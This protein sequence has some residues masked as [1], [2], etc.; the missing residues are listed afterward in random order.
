MNAELAEALKR[1]AAD[2]EAAMDALVPVPETLEARVHES[3]RYSLFAGGKRLRPFLVMASGD[4]F[5]VPRAQSVRA[6]AAI[7]M[8]HTYS[9]IHDDLPCMDDDD[10]RRGKPT[11]HRQFDE[12]TAVLAGDALQP[13][14]IEV[15][16]DPATDADREIRIALAMTLVQAAGAEGMVGGQMIDLQA[17]TTSYDLDQISRLQNMKTGALIAW[18]CEAGAILG[19][20]TGAERA[21]L[22]AYGLD[23]GLAFQI[24]DDILDIEASPEEM[25]K[26]TAKD[27]DAGKETFITLMGLDG[28]RARA[29]ELVHNA[30]ARLDLFGE[31]AF[32][33]REV[34]EYVIN[35]RS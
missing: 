26:A 25:G 9:L 14:A 11:N 1:A 18:S 24:A 7:E 34:A 27:A 29:A 12:A 10:L 8:I 19:H 32:L 6:A 22:K 20:A 4:L 5:H 21:A 16:L 33:L 13:K 31:R 2:V 3:M 15:L 23:L 28:A 35:R 30:V 17:E